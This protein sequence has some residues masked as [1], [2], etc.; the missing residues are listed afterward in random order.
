MV[1]MRKKDDVEDED[2]E[3]EDEGD[4]RNGG[5]DDNE[6]GK[7]D[8]GLK[9]KVTIMLMIHNCLI[10]VN[11]TAMREAQYC[12]LVIPLRLVCGCCEMPRIV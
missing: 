4:K 3:K 10:M 5:D 8:H 12:M 11:N 1:T 9:K 2:G 7:D 6:G